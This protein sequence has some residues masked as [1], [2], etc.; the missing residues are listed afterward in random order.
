MNE[1]QLI[2]LLGGG[3][4]H[5]ALLSSLLVASARA[6]SKLTAEEKAERSERRRLLSE[7]KARRAKIM[8]RT[9]PSCE[10]KLIR[11][12]RD[13]KNDYKRSWD[14]RDCGVAHTL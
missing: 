10:G 9:C 4:S 2:S 13:K 14:C 3:I 6:D 11:G 1:K 7:E 8:N 12:K 5:Y